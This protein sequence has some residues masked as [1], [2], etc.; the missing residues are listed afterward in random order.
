MR[1]EKAEVRSEKAEVRS[2][3]ADVRSEKKS[4]LRDFNNESLKLNISL[5][6]RFLHTKNILFIFSLNYKKMSLLYNLF[7]HL[8]FISCYNLPP[9]I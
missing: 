9:I 1:S 8:S 7:L 5:I 6:Q 4:Y 3:K 2:E